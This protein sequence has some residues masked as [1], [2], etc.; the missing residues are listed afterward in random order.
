MPTPPA[1]ADLAGGTCT[2]QIG[3]IWYDTCLPQIRECPAF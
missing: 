2:A 3:T 1:I